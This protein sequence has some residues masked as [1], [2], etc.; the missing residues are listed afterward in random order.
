MALFSDRFF[1]IHRKS[2]MKTYILSM[3]ETLIGCFIA[4]LLELSG[5]NFLRIGS[6]EAKNTTGYNLYL[7]ISIS[8]HTKRNWEF[9]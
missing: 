8:K 1:Q 4:K 7:M 9:R 6:I 2:R 3:E 5:T